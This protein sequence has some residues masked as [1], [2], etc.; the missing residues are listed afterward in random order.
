MTHAR[1]PLKMKGVQIGSALVNED[2]TI[3]LTMGPNN[4]LGRELLEHIKIGLV[5]GLTISPI[6]NPAV[7]GKLITRVENEQPLPAHGGFQID[8]E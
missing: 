4:A 5:F 1:I 2:G 7:D 6:I 8:K 3:Q